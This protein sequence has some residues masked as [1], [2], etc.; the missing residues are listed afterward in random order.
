MLALWRM[1]LDS[2]PRTDHFKA[3]CDPNRHPFTDAIVDVYGVPGVDGTGQHH[4][5]EDGRAARVAGATASGTWVK[6]EW[7]IDNDSGAGNG[8]LD[9]PNGY[10]PKA[11]AVLLLSFFLFFWK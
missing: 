6:E 1:C 3:D 2:S 11:G 9:A 8:A 7:T 10:D 4:E 5:F